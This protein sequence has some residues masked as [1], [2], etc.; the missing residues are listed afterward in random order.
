MRT[1]ENIT[2][3]DELNRNMETAG[4][5]RKY[6]IDYCCKGELPVRT[7]ARAAL[8]NPVS[9]EK[10]LKKIKAPLN[11]AKDTGRLEPGALIAHLVEEQHAFVKETIPVI[12]YYAQRVVQRN[13]ETY[14]ELIQVQRLFSEV[15]TSLEAQM[16]LKEDVLFPTISQLISWAEKALPITETSRENLKARMNLMKEQHLETIYTFKKIARLTND[17]QIPPDVRNPFRV[18]YQQLEELEQKLYQQF[19]LQHNILFPKV[20]QLA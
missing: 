1:F 16:K 3:A 2:V 19:H 10:E 9:L 6:G 18:L 17:Y 13:A 11:E 14:P 12:T 20:S 15:T 8:A 4:I 5:F 7:A